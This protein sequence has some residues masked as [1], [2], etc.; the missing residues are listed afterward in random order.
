MPSTGCGWWVLHAPA[1]EH[2]HATKRCPGPPHPTPALPSTPPGLTAFGRR[3][4]LIAGGTL[5]ME[6]VRAAW[7]FA[8]AHDVPV[9]GFLEEECLTHKMH[10]E[11]EELHHR[12]VGVAQRGAARCPPH[13]GCSTARHAQHSAQC[14]MPCAAQYV[15]PCHATHSTAW[16]RGWLVAAA[17]WKG[18]TR[19]LPT[20]LLPAL[21]VLRAA[22]GAHPA[23][24]R[25]AGARAAQAAVHDAAR[26][27]LQPQLWWVLRCCCMRCRAGSSRAPQ[28]EPEFACAWLTTCCQSTQRLRG[29]GRSACTHVPA[30]CRLAPEAPLG[31]GPGG[32][33]CRDDAGGARHARC[34]AC[35]LRAGSCASCAVPPPAVRVD[36]DMPQGP[37]LPR[38]A[39]HPPALPAEVVPSGERFQGGGREGE[40]SR[41]PMANAAC[42]HL[43]H[44]PGPPELHAPLRRRPSVPRAAPGVQAGTSGAPSSTCWRTW[45]CRPPT[46]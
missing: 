39:C 1:A 34:A 13:C 12:W 35:A 32:S 23:G 38:R 22:C 4:Q 10:P 44:V 28:T 6:V 3:G 2:T 19:V 36:A 14:T 33:G 45:G 7:E 16:H 21:Q 40:G 31:R 17:G 41:R 43:R 9:C 42:P 27:A 20:P 37:D 15:T 5:P 25:A 24:R 30:G 18:P 29:R 11:L 26:G 8:A 46:W